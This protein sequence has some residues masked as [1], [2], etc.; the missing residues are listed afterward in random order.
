[1]FEGYSPNNNEIR[2]SSPDQAETF[3]TLEGEDAFEKA[4]SQILDDLPGASDI[5]QPRDY[6]GILEEAKVTDQ[7]KGILEEIATKLPT[8]EEAQIA[9][10]IQEKIK[11]AVLKRLEEMEA[12][13]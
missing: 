12:A 1:M 5:I 6:Q 4:M 10:P 3:G 8:I 7:E 11:N 9:Q 2:P 13:V